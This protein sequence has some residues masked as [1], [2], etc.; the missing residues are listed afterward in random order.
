MTEEQASEIVRRDIA[1]ALAISGRIAE[2][3]R[4][5]QERLKRRSSSPKNFEA[6][7]EAFCSP[8]LRS[9]RDFNSSTAF[10][11]APRPKAPDTGGVTFHFSVTH[12]SKTNRTVEAYAGRAPSGNA[13]QHESY[14][15]RGGAAETFVDPDFKAFSPEHAVGGQDYIER[16]S[17]SEAFQ[18]GEG[19]IVSS[20]GNIAETKEERL[21]F[22]EKL[23]AFEQSPRG[24]K[25]TIN[26]F[27]GADFWAAVDQHADAGK[28][29]PAALARAREHCVSDIR[30]FDV[31]L[32]D[33]E[34]I[35]LLKFAHSMGDFQTDGAIKVSSG[36]GGRIQTKIVAELPHE[37][38]PAQRLALAKEYCAEFERLGLLYWAV[39]HAPDKHND[40]R[41]FHLHIALSERPAKRVPHP[42]SGQMVW[43]FEIAETYQTEC[44]HTRTRYP[45]AQEKN[46]DV[47]TPTWVTKERRRFCTITNKVLE[48]SGNSKRYDARSYAKMGVAQKAKD[49]IDPKIYAK[50]RKGQITE[51]GLE[52][53]RQQWEAAAHDLDQQGRQVATKAVHTSYRNR[54]FFTT[55][56]SAGHADAKRF[57]E[58]TRRAADLNSLVI[59][60]VAAHFATNFVADKMVS[61]ARLKKPAQR[62]KVDK[63]LIEVAS[64]IRATE[65]THFEAIADRFAAEYRKTASQIA[66]IRADFA[67]S[68][69]K[70][71]F[72]QLLDLMAP[73]NQS[74]GEQPRRA[75]SLEEITAMTASW[76]PKHTSL[77]DA[78]SKPAPQAPRESAIDRL[79]GKNFF[80]PKKAGKEIDR[81]AKSVPSAKAPPPKGPIS[82]R[83]T[84][85]PPAD[86]RG[87]PATAK[88]PSPSDHA[89]TQTTPIAASEQ[90]DKASEAPSGTTQTIKAST[91]LGTQ[92]S[93]PGVERDLPSK[94]NQVKT[95]VV[96]AKHQVQLEP[97]PNQPVDSSNVTPD[98]AEERKERKKRKKVPSVADSKKEQSTE[99]AAKRE[100]QRRAM[101]M[102]RRKARGQGR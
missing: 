7:M 43:D 33:K 18:S 5:A 19:I 35:A 47:H 40:R 3:E 10:K 98:D 31:T 94:N 82:D 69:H 32:K 102:R 42:D 48:A 76:F 92:H 100:A 51:Q 8:G 2:A 37:I 72:G 71:L 55:L 66:H 84:V 23:E 34:A 46:R 41:N 16:L 30:P 11:T 73:S 13:A 17:A 53:A 81:A 20:F 27:R 61:R 70:Q 77:C 15:E 1:R 65:A 60:A 29:V 59:S 56:H 49:R 96:P 75:M 99:D 62:T 95:P 54:I 4:R 28:G 57:R 89:Q 64:E 79:L 39:I 74:P 21:A 91:L 67:R 80:D 63:I 6:L 87:A 52:A 22:W 14:I 12:V 85:S 90:M 101:I 86:P 45:Q 58:L 68:F 50:E 97:R 78:P 93:D 38:T 26:L 83:G 9:A 25:F 44:R 24:H 36:R 88:R